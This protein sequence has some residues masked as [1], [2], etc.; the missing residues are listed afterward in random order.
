MVII[1][2]KSEIDKIRE[3]CQ[4]VSDVL[5]LL[6]RYI[7]EGAKT[8]ELDLI[9]E[10]FIKSCGATPAFKGYKMQGISH[11]YPAALCISINEEVIHGI[12]GDRKIENGDIVSVDVGVLK[13]SF[14]GDGAKTFAV[15]NVSD[16]KKKLMDVTEKSL[17]LGIGQAKSGNKLFDISK[18]VQDYVE[19]NNFSVVREMVG[20]GVGKYLHE[21][22]Q[23][24][25]YV[26]KKNIGKQNIILKE[27][28]TLAIEPMVN[29]GNYT[30]KTKK[31]G[32]TIY[33]ADMLPSAHFEHT[34]L[35]RN[36]EAEILTV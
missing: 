26:P 15:G 36:G 28:M 6:E 19:K 30:I 21:P 35:V 18:A 1:K 23:I 32:W 22:P 5:K 29:M 31:D 3:S 8:K 25:N 33:T 7:K 14:F 11:P 24:P 4:I 34:V 16:A 12:P 2:T 9:A 17:Y 10:D 13:N 20:H 27:G